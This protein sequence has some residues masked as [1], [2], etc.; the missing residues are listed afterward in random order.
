MCLKHAYKTKLSPTGYGWKWLR[1]LGEEITTPCRDFPVE[2]NVWMK[3]NANVPHLPVLYPL[4]FHIFTKRKEA[5]NSAWGG[6]PY[7]V[8]FRVQYR[9]AH[10]SGRGDGIGGD[11]C[12]QV[13][14][15]E[16]RVIPKKEKRH[17][18]QK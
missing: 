8:L 7:A 12:K 17:A 13:V 4:G 16:M 2:L 10:T 1:V 9:G 14:T 18:K 5:L 6:L 15:A 3:S 11:H